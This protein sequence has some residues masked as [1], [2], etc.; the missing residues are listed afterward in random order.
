MNYFTHVATLPFGDI[1]LSTEKD[2]ITLSLTPA[3][4]NEFRP[5]VKIGTETKDDEPYPHVD[6]YDKHHFPELPALTTHIN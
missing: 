3:G 2:E 1:Y 4:T 5:L 6:V